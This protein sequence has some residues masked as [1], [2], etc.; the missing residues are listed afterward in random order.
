LRS[1]YAVPGW[2][3]RQRRIINLGDCDKRKSA[4]QKP[5]IKHF[6]VAGVVIDGRAELM[7]KPPLR[8]SNL[9]CGPLA[10]GRAEV[11]MNIQ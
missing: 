11:S 7:A 10:A 6:C 4:A 2:E 9:S 3:E 5:E 1:N 8:L